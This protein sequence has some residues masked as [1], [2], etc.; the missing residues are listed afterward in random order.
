MLFSTESVAVETGLETKTGLENCKSNLS[1]TVY[2]LMYETCIQL[3]HT[4]DSAA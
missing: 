3:P 4:H 2:I 1:P